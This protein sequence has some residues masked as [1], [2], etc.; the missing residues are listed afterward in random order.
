MWIDGV[1]RPRSDKRAG[2][3]IDFSDGICNYNVYNV[4]LKK[5]AFSGLG[6]GRCTFSFRAKPFY[7]VYVAPLHCTKLQKCPS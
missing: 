6:G 5:L 1:T 7:Q 3:L 2:N 4:Q